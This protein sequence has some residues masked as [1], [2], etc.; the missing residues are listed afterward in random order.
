MTR[1]EE[2]TWDAA[3]RGGRMRVGARVFIDEGTAP[4]VIGRRAIP[5]FAVTSSHRTGSS[6]GVTPV[7]GRQQEQAVPAYA[8]SKSTSWLA[9]TALRSRRQMPSQQICV[10][11]AAPFDFR[12]TKTALGL[13]FQ[14]V[15]VL[16]KA[17]ITR[18]LS[19]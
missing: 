5:F 13:R 15:G 10:L 18:P 14:Y 3:L 1:G 6:Y 7:E 4:G 12:S 9:D 19:G 17:P 8:L 11:F 16:F 2:G